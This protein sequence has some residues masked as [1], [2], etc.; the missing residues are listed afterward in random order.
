[1]SLM[2]MPAHTTVPP[3]PTARKAAGTSAPMGAYRIAAS[4]GSGGAA[5]EPPAHSA[6]SERAKRCVS[7]AGERE[8]PAALEARDLRH[9]VGGR[10]EAVD[11][12]CSRVTRGRERAIADQ[13][14]AEQR[15][16]FRGRVALRQGKAVA[17]VGKRKFGVASVDVVAGEAR[18]VAQ[19][20]PAPS[21]IVAI[22]AGP[23]EPGH[24]HALSDAE[25]L[26]ARSPFDDLA[27]DLMSRNGGPSQSGQFPVRDVKVGAAQAARENA[28][29]KLSRIGLADFTIDEPERLAGGGEL[30]R[31]HFLSR[32]RRGDACDR[33]F[34]HWML[35]GTWVKVQ[36]PGGPPG[37]P[38]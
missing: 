20:F 37:S 33:G 27:D 6:P 10:A 11:A 31:A 36:A 28:Q 34:R 21:A 38:R 5:S 9:D 2:W 18:A 25:T 23:A 22:P 7:G 1:M 17:A 4:S 8:E 35:C 24:A 14:R 26:R 32:L 29:E 16:G 19:V 30:H 12:E 3:L 15:R 13:A